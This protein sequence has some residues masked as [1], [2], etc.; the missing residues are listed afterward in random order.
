VVDIFD[1]VDE[2]LR[3]E[4][5]QKFLQQYG[6]LILAFGMLIVAG[7]G[8]WQAWRWWEARQDLAAATAYIGAMSLADRAGRTDASAQAA[9]ASAFERVAQRAPKGYATLARLRAAALLADI[10]KRTDADS[11]WDQVAGDRAA[12]PLLRD[13]ATLLWAEGHIADADPDMIAARLAPLE[14]AGSP[15]RPLALEAHALVE[16]RRGRPEA[17]RDI[18]KGLAQDATAPD[19]VRGR[20]AVLLG[21]LGA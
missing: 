5:A 17:G 12:D 6:G 9:A 16:L 18:L 13:V 7:A 21:Q 8:A 4:R 10:G 2:D 3:A 1:E 11:L 14:A 15:V 20:A 19:G